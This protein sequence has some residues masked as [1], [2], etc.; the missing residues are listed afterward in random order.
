MIGV[1]LLTS[2]APTRGSHLVLP[3]SSPKSGN[4]DHDRSLSMQGERRW[5]PKGLVTY[6][7]KAG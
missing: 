3:G 1:D 5:I 2:D 4:H 6:Y 7:E